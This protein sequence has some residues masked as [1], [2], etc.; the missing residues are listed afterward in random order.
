L[1]LAPFLFFLSA[2]EFE[3]TASSKASGGFS[4]G[5]GGGA[6]GLGGGGIF[7][8]DMHIINSLLGYRLRIRT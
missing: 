2:D 5:G 7:G 4:G 6:G 3:S 8:A 1:A